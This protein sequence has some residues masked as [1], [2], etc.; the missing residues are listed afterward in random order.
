M[1]KVFTKGRGRPPSD[2]R[3]I[4]ITVRLAPDLGDF[5]AARTA[6]TGRSTSQEIELLLSQGALIE[7]ILDCLVGA[8]PPDDV[9]REAG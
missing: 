7:R 3:R 9:P 2:R 6:E 1:E 8:P 4:R 5:I